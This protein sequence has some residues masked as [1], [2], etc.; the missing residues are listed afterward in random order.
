MTRQ[1]DAAGPPS[2]LAMELYAALY[3]VTCLRSREDMLM[4]A[5]RI[6][7]GKYQR[8]APLMFNELAPPFE[9]VTAPS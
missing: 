2:I 3:R 8:H 7:A 4:K 5:S 6:S 1:P 9:G